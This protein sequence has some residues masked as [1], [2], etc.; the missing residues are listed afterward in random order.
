MR[1]RLV[2]ISPKE[3]KTARPEVLV[4]RPPGG[5]FLCSADELFQPKRLENLARPF[6]CGGQSERG[7]TATDE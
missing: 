3:N 5:R 1:D 4:K 7:T 6:G 2:Q